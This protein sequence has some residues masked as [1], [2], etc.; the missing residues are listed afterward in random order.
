MRPT[1]S[2]SSL[3]T[4]TVGLAMGAVALCNA[5]AFAA[6]HHHHMMADMNTP[7]TPMAAPMMV[8]PTPLTGTV[9]RYYVDPTGYVSAV[10]VQT[11]SGNQMVTFGPGMAQQLTQTY[12][13][14]STANLYVDSN[15]E[16]L[17]MGA[18]MPAPSAMWMV[19]HVTTRDMLKSV[20]YTTIGARQMTISGQLTGYIPD[21]QGDVLAI[22][23]DHT[24]LIRVPMESRQGAD[25]DLTPDGVRP[26]FKGEDVQAVGYPE[27]PHYG[28]VSRF[29]TRLIATAIDING[30]PLGARGF[31][32][33]LRA[34]KAVFDFNLPAFG[35]G[36]PDEAKAG[37]QGYTTYTSGTSMT[38][39]G[40]NGSSP[41]V[42]AR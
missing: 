7:T 3:C 16:L 23:L 29:D 22:V 32:R 35:S 8:Q 27:A 39:A 11:A 17:G 1:F 42:M 40:N 4:K 33:V 41:S 24:K 36:S 10:D 14:G 12:P 18:N 30:I 9:T 6:H 19:N 2:S 15:N 25:P 31:G 20:P 34:R 21:R 28:A 13:V 5:T 38:S 26:L 37:R